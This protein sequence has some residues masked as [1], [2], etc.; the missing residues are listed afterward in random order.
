VHSGARLIPGLRSEDASGIA[1][2][3]ASVEAA[4]Q[5]GRSTGPAI[6]FEPHDLR[7]ALITDVLREMTSPSSSGCRFSR[8]PGVQGPGQPT[9]EE[10]FK[11]FVA[12]ERS[13]FR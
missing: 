3:R 13:S 4:F 2:L 5:Q 8:P 9:T 1:A 7:R 6:D 11:R 12:V 10:L